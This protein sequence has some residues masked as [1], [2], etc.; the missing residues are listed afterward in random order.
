MKLG[1]VI[2]LAAL[3]CGIGYL[4]VACRP[5]W[6]FDRLETNAQKAISPEELEAWA[7]EL[8]SRYPDGHWFKR[9][10]LS[11]NI[12]PKLLALAPRVGPSVYIYPAEKDDKGERIRVYW[13]S[14]FL[15]AKGFSIGTT[16]YVGNGTLW[17]P[18]IYFYKR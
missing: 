8:M 11:N 10:E 2:A 3:L 16:N 4:W 7:M 18:G 6:E 5:V 12:P 15:G 14:G 9:S 1:S 13:G 17:K